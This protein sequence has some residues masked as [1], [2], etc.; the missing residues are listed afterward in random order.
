M[1]LGLDKL[2]MYGDKVKI[3][4]G[5]YK[6]KIA[7]VSQVMPNGLIGIDINGRHLYSKSKDLKKL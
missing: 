7:F 5:M 2:I 6:G 1:G 4:S 3:K